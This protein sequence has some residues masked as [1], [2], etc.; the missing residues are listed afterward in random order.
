MKLGEIKIE[1][2]KLMSI[3]YSFDV[4]VDDLQS[5]VSDENYGG[6]LVNMAGAIKRALDRIENACVL[7]QK[8]KILT[9]YDFV[10]GRH[11][12][13]FDT[14]KIDDCYMIDRVTA[15]YDDGTYCG[16]VDFTMEGDNILFKNELATY[17]I[18]Y[19]PTA[20]DITDTLNE[21]ELPIPD[22]LARIIPYFIKGDLYQEE[23]PS[24]ASDAR[25]IFEAS[26]DD[27]K[28][29]TQSTQTKVK[30]VLRML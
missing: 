24:L 17:T 12:L 13:K 22:K 30:K 15:E 16:N 26:L 27:M 25:N 10:V 4:G 18:I 3:N 29:P 14:S 1:A 8:T 6:Y 11:F 20:P 2:L 28:K 7:P 9:T 19:Y 23:E 5:L 21:A